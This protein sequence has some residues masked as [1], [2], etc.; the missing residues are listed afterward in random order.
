VDV[1]AL[2]GVNLTVREG[3]FVCLL[4]PSARYTVSAARKALLKGAAL[5]D[6][7]GELFALTLQAAVLIPVGAALLGTPSPWR[8]GGRPC[9]SPLQPFRPRVLSARCREPARL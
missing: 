1:Y 5:G 7:A 9:T 6:V 3:E 2:N 4:G 8:G